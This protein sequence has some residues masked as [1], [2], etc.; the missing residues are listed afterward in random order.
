MA[1]VIKISLL[2][3]LCALTIAALDQPVDLTVVPGAIGADVVTA[4]ISRI[5]DEAIFSTDRRLLRR[6]AFVETR[7]GENLS[8]GGGI[9]NVR[10]SDFARTMLSDQAILARIS[11]LL[12][13]DSNLN[14]ATWSEVQF[15]N[16]NI[17]LLS[18][19]AARLVIE[20]AEMTFEP[21]PTSSDIVGQA[22]FWRLRYNPDGD[23]DMFRE[24]VE[25]L[26]QNE[27]MK[28]IMI[29]ITFILFVFSSMHCKLRHHICS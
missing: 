18:A 12:Q 25:Q 11:Q 21:I 2:L 6:I 26:I 14:F 22:T 27:G 15:A 9:W 24:A 19:L 3:L 29:C 28:S 4:T 8:M 1:R 23:V 16:L 17:P 7:D 20:L 10:Q 5:E 13:M